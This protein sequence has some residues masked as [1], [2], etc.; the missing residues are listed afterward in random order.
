MPSPLH[1]VSLSPPSWVEEVQVEVVRHRSQTQQMSQNH[2]ASEVD[3]HSSLASEVDLHS[4]SVSVYL[5]AL[6]V[7]AA[8]LEVEKVLAPTVDPLESVE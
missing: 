6:A 7:V 2:S 3:L 8:T 4:S 5:A 1:D